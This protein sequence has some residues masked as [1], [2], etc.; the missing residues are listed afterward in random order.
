M[1]ESIVLGRA[2]NSLFHMHFND[3]FAVGRRHDRRLGP[4]VGYIEMLDWLDRTG[5]EG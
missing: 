4:Y 5:Y 2:G 3:N 1:G